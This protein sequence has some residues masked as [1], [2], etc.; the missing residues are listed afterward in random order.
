MTSEQGRAA[1]SVAGVAEDTDEFGLATATPSLYGTEP[2]V[3][4]SPWDTD[5]D[6][7]G[8]PAEA[9]HSR[10]ADKRARV[11]EQLRL[12]RLRLYSYC[13]TLSACVLALMAF[14]YLITGTADHDAGFTSIGFLFVAMMV[15]M[16]WAAMR[17][18]RAG[19]Q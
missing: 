4:P 1:R 3:T 11:K 5:D 7:F 6:L 9:P 8:A 17:V 15:G 19:E 12:S 18:T 10:S 14:M 2:G 16:L 13:M